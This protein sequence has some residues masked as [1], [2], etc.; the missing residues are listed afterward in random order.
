ML[1]LINSIFREKTYTYNFVFQHQQQK[2]KLGDHRALV[3]T[4]RDNLV[5][6]IK[7]KGPR[8][9]KFRNTW[10]IRYINSA[11][12]HS[13][14]YILAWI[15]QKYIVV[16]WEI[17]FYVFGDSLKCHMLLN[18]SIFVSAKCSSIIKILYIKYKIQTII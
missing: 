11:L 16:V 13:T 17:F 10:G 18:Y 1:F 9:A 6:F 15:F 4:V 8:A 3:L 12:G 14:L 2:K 7:Y 5:A